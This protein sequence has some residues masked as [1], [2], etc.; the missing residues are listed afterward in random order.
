IDHKSGRIIRRLTE[1]WGIDTSPSFSPDCKQIAFVSDRVGGPQIYRVDADGSSK[2]QR[3]T[4]Q[5][6]YNTT[7]DWSPDGKYV[8]FSGRGG[9]GHNIFMVDMGG[10][11]VRLTGGSGSNE[12]PSWS[13]NGN[14]VVFTSNRDGGAPNIYIMTKDGFTQTRITHNGGYD[15]P[16]WQR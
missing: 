16:A 13:P 5:G 15:A 9:G 14:Y 3:L 7:P 8:L 2:P 6:S 11:V 1:H 4:R 12:N 10:L